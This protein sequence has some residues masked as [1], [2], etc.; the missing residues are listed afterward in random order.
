VALGLIAIYD[1]QHEANIGMCGVRADYDGG[2]G[3]VEQSSR[4]HSGL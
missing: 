4:R 3:A 2:F 1:I